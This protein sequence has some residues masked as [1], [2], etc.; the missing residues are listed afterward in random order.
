MGAGCSVGAAKAFQAMKHVEFLKHK[1]SD[2]L[3][4]LLNNSETSQF[5]NF[6][7]ENWLSSSNL[8]AHSQKFTSLAMPAALNSLFE[9]ILHKIPQERPYVEP[10]TEAELR[11]RLKKE[12]LDKEKGIP[13]DVICETLSENEAC[14]VR[15]L[16]IFVWS[17]VEAN[18]IH[19][20]LHQIVIPQI[21]ETC[22]RVGVCIIWVDF[23]W[24]SS[25]ALTAESSPPHLSRKNFSEMQEMV[26]AEMERCFCLSPLLNFFSMTAD[27]RDENASLGL[28][29][30]A[31]KF[32]ISQWIKAS[33]TLAATFIEKAYPGYATA[34]DPMEIIALDV[35]VEEED[36]ASAKEIELTLEGICGGSASL[37]D[38]DNL[39]ITNEMIASLISDPTEIILRRRMKLELGS[40]SGLFPLSKCKSMVSYCYYGCFNRLFSSRSGVVQQRPDF[41][42]NPVLSKKQSRELEPMSRLT[43]TMELLFDMRNNVQFLHQRNNF[44]QEKI[45]EEHVSHFCSSATEHII[46]RLKLAIVE[47]QKFLPG[48]LD[49]QF[50]FKMMRDAVLN[51]CWDTATVGILQLCWLPDIAREWKH[52]SSIISD[53]LL[54]EKRL[55]QTEEAVNEKDFFKK[56]SQGF[57]QDSYDSEYNKAAL[58]A[59][60]DDYEET[61]FWRLLEER[62]KR[63]G[64][65]SAKEKRDKKNA[66]TVAAKDLFQQQASNIEANAKLSELKGSIAESLASF[67]EDFGLLADIMSIKRHGCVL[68][69]DSGDSCAISSIMN[70]L[71]VLKVKLTSLAGFKHIQKFNIITR[72]VMLED[73][74]CNFSDLVTSICEE[75]AGRF[76]SDCDQVQTFISVDFTNHCEAQKLSAFLNAI[77]EEQ[78]T[79]IFC[80]GIQ[81][82][83]QSDKISSDICPA[84]IPPW[85]LFILHTVCPPSRAAETLIRSSFRGKCEIFGG[86]SQ[87]S[88]NS[89]V[90]M[91]EQLFIAGCQQL[92]AR[93]LA[94]CKSVFCAEHGVMTTRCH[95]FMFG[96]CMEWDTFAD[97]HGL[98]KLSSEMKD[99]PNE[100]IVKHYILGT[101][102]KFRLHK[103]STFAVLSLMAAS[104]AEIPFNLISAFVKFV[105]KKNSDTLV[106]GFHLHASSST[107]DVLKLLFEIHKEMNIGQDTVR[108]T[109]WCLFFTHF[110]ILMRPTVSLRGANECY[111]LND[112]I[113]KRD[114]QIATEAIVSQNFSK[115]V[116][117]A[118]RYYEPWK[119]QLASVE[120]QAINA[121]KIR[122]L[123][124]LVMDL[125]LQTFALDLLLDFDFVSHHFEAGLAT[126]LEMLYIQASQFAGNPELLRNSTILRDIQ[127]FIVHNKVLFLSGLKY[128]L[129][130]LLF[131]FNG[132]SKYFEEI[133]AF[134]EKKKIRG[135]VVNSVWLKNTSEFGKR[136]TLRWISDSKGRVTAW[137]MINELNYRYCAVCIDGPQSQLLILATDTG[138]TVWNS[139]VNL[140]TESQICIK[141]SNNDDFIVSCS[142]VRVFLWKKIG[143]YA[144][145]GYCAV[146]SFQLL[147]HHISGFDLSPSDLNFCTFSDSEGLTVTSWSIVT[148]VSAADKLDHM[149]L[150]VT[151][152]YHVGL[153]S[154]LKFACFLTWDNVLLTSESSGELSLNFIHQSSFGLTTNPGS[155][156][157]EIVRWSIP[158]HSSTETKASSMQWMK[159]R[160]LLVLSDLNFVIFYEVIINFDNASSPVASVSALKKLQNGFAPA[161]WYSSP[162][163]SVEILDPSLP[164]LGMNVVNDN[165]NLEGTFL[166]IIVT[167][168]GVMVW[169]TEPYNNLPEQILIEFNGTES[170]VERVIVKKEG[171]LILNCTD[172][173]IVQRDLEVSRYGMFDS[174]PSNG[175]VDDVHFTSNNSMIV[176]SCKSGEVSLYSGTSGFLKVRQ[177]MNEFSISVCSS[178]SN[179]MNVIYSGGISG[180]IACFSLKSGSQLPSLRSHQSVVTAMSMSISDLMLA[181]GDSTGNLSIWSTR[182]GQLLLNIPSAH[183]DS[184]TH[185]K[186]SHDNSTIWS[187]SADGRVTS[188]FCKDGQKLHDSKVSDASTQSFDISSN[189]YVAPLSIR[190]LST[191]FCYF[192]NLIDHRQLVATCGNDGKTKVWNIPATPTLDKTKSRK[193][194]SSFKLRVECIIFERPLVQSVIFAKEDASIVA[195]SCANGTMRLFST[196][197]GL[198]LLTLNCPGVTRI[199]ISSNYDYLA[200]TTKSGNCSVFSLH[201]D[202]V[203]VAKETGSNS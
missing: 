64:T 76:I 139:P 166:A 53:C 162:I 18:L 131:N 129:L 93:A 62:K 103:I 60:N 179:L 195:A 122:E 185:V 164:E 120:N 167:K 181:S 135:E 108:T 61:N 24:A 107:K 133:F 132:G 59:L 113:L 104:R 159:Q 157:T 82:L 85:V 116:L 63:E 19:Q 175:C 14:G 4:G 5:T 202:D 152:V 194:K 160:N 191:W 156:M 22:K 68:L 46:E 158:N 10:E 142:R 119:Y 118:S 176:C 65:L 52:T 144:D 86:I 34:S 112:G 184:I 26:E 80:Y 7:Y 49:G 99:H 148:D 29:L 12:R 172:Q 71:G 43:R 17:N 36:N 124:P 141:S 78:P 189:M 98:L 23:R 125:G 92:D 169:S 45:L 20:A 102:K 89:Y 150:A 2:S 138:Q 33:R 171:S 11:K 188:W 35:D 130:S 161:S 153:A 96:K 149:H 147:K 203:E 16:R 137:N 30:R 54:S 69:Y 6:A 201:S 70:A 100:V 163:L 128:D 177:M 90:A 114:V 25:S 41:F 55:L 165:Q 42:R 173:S 44:E 117:L 183:S 13:A 94:L 84:R 197:S 74:V 66:M 110:R 87:S 21:A 187:S 48:V 174:N 196:T 28:P 47:R 136:D 134:R 83:F 198:V 37:I 180:D 145:S 81:N 182:A 170:L 38:E 126:S 140:I 151:S 106:N 123:L 9:D 143:T 200:I 193:S 56:A 127:R 146:H 1:T 58:S 168:T 190:D 199:A 121:T 178:F 51:R 192:N 79:V 31:P 67:V 88:R 50:H 109:E 111:V 101:I 57:S 155:S 77:P 8:K 40:D 15:Y 72:G 27:D 73:A 186:F 97:D 3:A 95:I 39:A 32:I 75:L 115:M 91:V 105:K 154:I